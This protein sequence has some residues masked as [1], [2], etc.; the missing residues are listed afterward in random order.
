MMTLDRMP[1][2]DKRFPNTLF[3]GAR[4]M[5][6][7]LQNEGHAVSY[8]RIRR[9]APLKHAT[10]I[11]QKPDISKPATGHKTHLY[12]LGGLRVEQPN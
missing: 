4:Q 8:K 3:Y 7:H 11:Y 9:L 10:P 1:L 6:W 12:L 2:N 5:T